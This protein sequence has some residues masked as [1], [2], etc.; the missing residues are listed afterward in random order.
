MSQTS[1]TPD[2]AAAGTRF[3]AIAKKLFVRF[4]I[5]PLL[6]IIVIAYFGIQEPRFLSAINLT[7]VARQSTFLMIIAMAQMIVL[8]TAGMDL[9]V[10]ALIGLVTVVAGV[11][12]KTLIAGGMDVGTAI[13]IGMA[14]GLGVSLLVGAFNATCVALI[15]LSPFIATLGTMTAL[16]GIS[17]MVSG[18]VPVGGLPREFAQVFAIERY[19][20]FQM[21]IIATV[22]V[23]LALY[24]VLNHTV[25]GRYLYAIGS[26]ARAA[27]LSGINVNVVPFIAYMLCSFIT[28]IAGLLVLARTSTGGAGIG[29]EYGLQSVTACVIAGVSLFGGTG[30]IGGV[31]MGALFLALLSNGMNILQVQSYSQMVVLGGIL[32]LALIGDRIRMRLV[33][34]KS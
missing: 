7:N 5:L 33:G 28:G 8:I 20:G 27:R 26:N 4:G 31:V 25:L 14:A 30:R 3:G 13:G 9:S 1:T 15:G 2:Q 12:M 19:L 16:T 34:Q 6:L 29:S 32:I 21:P 22:V 11:V 17:L 23:F 24:F 10:G 18:G